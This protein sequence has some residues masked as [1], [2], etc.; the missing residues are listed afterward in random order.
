ME[1]NIL[2]NNIKNCHN[3]SRKRCPNGSRKNKLGKCIKYKEKDNK[4]LELQK[5][6]EYKKNMLIEK[7]KHMRTILKQNEFLEVVKNDYNEYF[8]YIRQQKQDQIKALEL[9]NNY[10]KK[11]L[12]N[13]A[14]TKYN[15]EDAKEEQNKILNEITQIQ[16]NLNELIHDTNENINDNVD[17]DNTDENVF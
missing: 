4:L 15:I 10:I 14:L 16:K 17:N 7:H 13:D 3:G 11:L 6:I 2:K 8:T 9:L 12:L 5:I 1:Q